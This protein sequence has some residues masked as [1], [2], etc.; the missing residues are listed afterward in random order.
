M[1]LLKWL[2]FDAE[3]GSERKREID[4]G[5]RNVMKAVAAA[6]VAAAAAAALGTEAR[7]KPEPPAILPPSTKSSGV[8][9]STTVYLT[10]LY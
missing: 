3:S 8:T 4:P 1:N 6:P 7:P 2:G 9:L 10:T 5:R